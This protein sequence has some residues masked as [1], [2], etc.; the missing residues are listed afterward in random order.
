MN[1]FSADKFKVRKNGKNFICECLLYALYFRMCYL[2]SC[3]HH[4]DK[5]GGVDLIFTEE[6]IV[7]EGGEVHTF[8]KWQALTFD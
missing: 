7:T 4:A 5:G 8:R 6:L 2:I 3:A 1:I